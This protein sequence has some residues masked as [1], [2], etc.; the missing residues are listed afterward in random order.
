VEKGTS[1]SCAVSGGVEGSSDGATGHVDP[2]SVPAPMDFCMLCWTASQGDSPLFGNS[3]T[4]TSPPG[5]REATLKTAPCRV[6][7]SR[8]SHAC[9]SY[10]AAKPSTETEPYATPDVH[11][12]GIHRG[13][14]KKQNAVEHSAAISKTAGC[15]SGSVCPQHHARQRLDRLGLALWHVRARLPKT[16][17]TVHWRL[18]I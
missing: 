5:Q 11:V 1:I 17:G 3:L 8:L 9:G 6:V 15:S 18:A 12:H 7:R 13:H 4:T 16:P 10:L 14:G 2:I